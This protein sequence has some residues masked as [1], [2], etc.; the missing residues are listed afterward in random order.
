M[1]TIPGLADADG[2]P[3]A[4]YTWKIGKS[5]IPILQVRK[6]RHLPGWSVEESSF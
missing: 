5:I 4:L 1:M 3:Q 2:T 6:L